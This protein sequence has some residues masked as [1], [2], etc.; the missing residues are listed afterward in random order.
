MASRIHKV[1]AS[2]AVVLSLFGARR[3]NAGAI[4]TEVYQGTSTTTPAY[5]QVE[6]FCY[7]KNTTDPACASYRVCSGTWNPAVGALSTAVPAGS[8]RKCSATQSSLGVGQRRLT[9]RSTQVLSTDNVWVEDATTNKVIHV[10]SGLPACASGTST[11]HYDNPD[12]P[13]DACGAPTLNTGKLCDQPHVT[14]ATGACID[15]A[16]I[17]TWSANGESCSLYSSD[18]E[19]A[20]AGCRGD[21]GQVW[22]LMQQFSDTS[23]NSVKCAL[24]EMDFTDDSVLMTAMTGAASR[25]SAAGG[26]F[27]I[28]TDEGTAT[29]GTQGACN[30]N[31]GAGGVCA[32]GTLCCAS[33]FECAAGLCVTNEMA[34]LE[35]AAGGTVTPT[36]TTMNRPS[37]HVQFV[38]P[39]GLMHD[40]FCVFSGTGA[41]TVTMGTSNFKD[42]MTQNLDLRVFVTGSVTLKDRV[43]AEI[44]DMLGHCGG[45]FDDATQKWTVSCTTT[46]NTVRDNT[47][48]S[49]CGGSVDLYM[50]PWS[51]ALSASSLNTKI[52]GRVERKDSV[53]ADPVT[54]CGGFVGRCTNDLART[55]SPENPAAW[56]TECGTSNGGCV[57]SVSIEPYHYTALA[58]NTNACV[59]ADCSCTANTDCVGEY[60]CDTAK[61]KCA[62]DTC[63][64]DACFD[65]GLLASATRYRGSHFALTDNCMRRGIEKIYNAGGTVEILQDELFWYNIYSASRLLCNSLNPTDSANRFTVKVEN[66]VGKNHE[67]NFCI[68]TATGPICH[69][70]S[71]NVS[72]N[73]NNNNTEDSFLFYNNATVANA[74]TDHLNK[75]LYTRLSSV[76]ECSTSNS[77]TSLQQSTA[78]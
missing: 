14:S 29:T 40:K 72:T 32:A 78:F 1:V 12:S 54:K 43:S 45:V 13:F 42:T 36:S 41:P 74:F 77:D 56:A 69:V 35:R 20:E 49:I 66:W 62:K 25:I 60:T 33:G 4:V 26:T 53:L 48:L 39:T 70:G 15:P 30:A 67:K 52:R 27:Q 73:S 58:G 64:L 50:G 6:V 16:P 2:A 46:K 34:K 51:D 10:A 61:H 75:M 31:T 21:G 76:A 28:A 17:A 22:A 71:A 24:Y 63:T 68:E 44:D 18:P 38:A 37:G 11:Q 5:D 47:N 65:D 57:N 19:C 59:N 3:A 23:V 55:C 9:S 8:T 7:Q